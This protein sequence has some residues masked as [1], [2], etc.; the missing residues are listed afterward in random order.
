MNFIE[1]KI[2]QEGVDFIQPS[3]NDREYILTKPYEVL[4]QKGKT[5]FKIVV[6][7]YLNTDFG[8]TPFGWF[9]EAKTRGGYILHDFGYYQNTNNVKE[10]WYFAY[11]DGEWVEMV[12]DWKRKEWDELMNHMHRHHKVEQWKRTLVHRFVRLFG[13]P[14]WN[15]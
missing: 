3:K 13:E 8:T 2:P 14:F 9:N 6:P 4:W 10:P 11:I 7:A 5:V 12:A 15:S 1:A